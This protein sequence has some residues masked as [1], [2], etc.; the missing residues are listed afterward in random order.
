MELFVIIHQLLSQRFLQW[1]FCELSH[2][3]LQKF[4]FRDSTS[5]SSDASSIAYPYFFF[6]FCRYF[7]RFFF[8]GILSK[9][10]TSWFRSVVYLENIRR[11]INYPSKSMKKSSKDKSLKELSY[12]FFVKST[13]ELE[14]WFSGDL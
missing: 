6:S 9:K 14:E 12:D 5:S 13:K 11:F 3:F 10:T 7:S 1:F 8:C 4:V 2:R